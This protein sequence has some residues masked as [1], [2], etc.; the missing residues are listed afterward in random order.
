MVFETGYFPQSVF[1]EHMHDIALQKPDGFYTCVGMRSH[2]GL[3]GV[4]TYMMS[5]AHRSYLISGM[6]F[7]HE[8]YRENQITGSFGF[9]MLPTLHTSVSVTLLN[10][11]IKDHSSRYGYA[12]HMSA[13]YE[14]GDLLLGGWLNN[15]N[16]PRFNDVD[17]IPMVYTIRVQ[18]TMQNNLTFILAARGTHEW[19]PFY[20]AGISWAIYRSLV[21][22]VGANTDPLYYEYMLRI[23]VGR[24]AI[25]YTGTMHEY[26]GFS[27]NIQLTFEL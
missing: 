5:L 25:L 24:I 26:L 15:V 9:D 10:Y 17:A 3:D 23:P 21:V 20:N 18:Y 22:G 4:H 8:L 19:L 12:L 1:C 27:H 11:W 7:G 2:Y 16:T 14:K 13:Y 6:S